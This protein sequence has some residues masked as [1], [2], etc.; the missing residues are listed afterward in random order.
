MGTLFWEYYTL[1]EKATFASLEEFVSSIELKENARRG[2][3]GM[4]ESV[5]QLASRLIGA[6]DDW[7][8]TILSLVKEEILPP[9]LI[10][11]LMDVMRISVDPWRIDDIIFYSML[12]RTMETLEQVYL[13][14]TG[15]SEG[16]PTSIKSFN[17]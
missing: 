11:E 14:L 7:Q 2:V 17:K 12:V 4:A 10:G 1:A 5:L 6:R 3:R 8:D 16:Q 13:L 9:P 15:K